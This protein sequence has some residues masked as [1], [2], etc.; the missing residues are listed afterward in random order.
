[1]QLHLHCI[2]VVGVFVL[3]FFPLRLEFFFFGIFLTFPIVWE[4]SRKPSPL[5]QLAG[6]QQI[7]DIAV[8]A[9]QDAIH[10]HHGEGGPAGPH[11]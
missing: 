8:A 2:N 11:F 3:L 4:L 5:T 10:E 7:F 1:M 9:D 6:C